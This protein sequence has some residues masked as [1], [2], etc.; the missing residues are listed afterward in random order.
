MAGVVIWGWRAGRDRPS[1]LESCSGFYLAIDQ[2]RHDGADDR[3]DQPGRR[4]VQEVPIVLEERKDEPS[5]ERSDD[6]QDQSGHEAHGILA[7]HDGT[8]EESGDQADYQEPQDV[9]SI[10]F[11]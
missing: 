2:K 8:S 5:H 11:L 3:A 4:E 6:A 7:R 9:Q 1:T 10:S